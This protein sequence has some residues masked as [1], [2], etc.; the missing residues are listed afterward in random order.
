[1]HVIDSQ[2]ATA[3]AA[4]DIAVEVVREDSGI[5]LVVVGRLDATAGAV[6]E[7]AAAALVAIGEVQH[8][9]IDLQRIDGFTPDGAATVA[10]LTAIAAALPAGLRWRTGFGLGR[11]ALEVAYA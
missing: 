7:D 3:R 5:A 10:R 6:L 11:R 4:P 8:L 1:M 2:A 9:T